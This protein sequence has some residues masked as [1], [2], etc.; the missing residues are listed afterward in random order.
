MYTSDQLCETIR[1]VY[2]EVGACGEKIKTRF[3]QDNNAWEVQLKHGN[4]KLKTFVDPEDANP[5]I[6]GKQCIGLG[7][8]IFQLK[9]NLG[10]K[11]GNA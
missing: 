10:L 5:C 7:F 6:D 1:S 8:Q 3:D 11:G 2:P 9:D 4:R